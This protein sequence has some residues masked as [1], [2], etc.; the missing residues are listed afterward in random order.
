MIPPFYFFYYHSVSFPFSL[1]KNILQIYNFDAT[2]K[3]FL[4]QKCLLQ[5]VQIPLRKLRRTAE[6]LYLPN[7]Q[8]VE[9]AELNSNNLE[10]N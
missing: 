9:N 4:T 3:R 8:T 6:A 2:A 5:N 1:S 7:A 10:Q